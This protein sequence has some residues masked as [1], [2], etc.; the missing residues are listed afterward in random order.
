MKRTTARELLMQA[1][2]QMEARDSDD[3]GLVKG[4]I[5]E[6][7]SDR[8]QLEYIYDNFRIIDEH[9]EDIDKLIDENAEKWSI[10]RMPKADLAIARVAVGESLYG[11]TPG[12]VAINEAVEMAKK[13][14]GND[15]AKFING[16]L[17]KILK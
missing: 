9:L 5:P 8:N 10:K 3:I 2:F 6:G 7:E 11:D 14:G 16:L 1:V 12:S 13:F 4:L 15:S 17:G